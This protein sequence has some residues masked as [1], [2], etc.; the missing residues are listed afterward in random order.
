MEPSNFLQMTNDS[1]SSPA[2]IP[3]GRHA[4]EDEHEDE[5]E[6][7][8]D[9]DDEDAVIEEDE[10]IMEE[11]ELDYYQASGDP[12]GELLTHLTTIHRCVYIRM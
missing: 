8:E 3:T 5:D 10:E 6:D 9:E 4:E 1:A 7:D 12:I 11:E 2:V